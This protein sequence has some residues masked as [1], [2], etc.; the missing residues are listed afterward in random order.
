MAVGVPVLGLPGGV[1]F[2]TELA[3]T[4]TV[5]MLAMDIQKCSRW[6]KLKKIFL[7]GKPDP[8]EVY[9]AEQ[10]QIELPTGED[11]LDGGEVMKGWEPVIIR[12]LVP[13]SKRLGIRAVLYMLV[14]YLMAV[15]PLFLE[16]EYAGLASFLN[17]FAAFAAIPF[18]IIFIKKVMKKEIYKGRPFV[19]LC[20]NV[21]YILSFLAIPLTAI[22]V[23]GR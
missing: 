16:G 3:A 23:S 11:I 4:L 21:L 13:A 14:L 22:A 7:S 10:A 15:S 17:I 9:D 12:K 1:I 6:N 5:A 20:I 18:E 8:M 19:Y 2:F